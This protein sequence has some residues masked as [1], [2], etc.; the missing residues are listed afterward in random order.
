VLAELAQALSKDGRTFVI[1]V[2]V[3]AED[4]RPGGDLEQEAAALSLERAR[5]AVEHLESKGV[6]KGRLTPRGGGL[7]KPGQLLFDVA[8]P[9][10]GPR[11]SLDQSGA[12]IA[13]AGAHP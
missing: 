7:A 11:A 12:S 5:A 13:I 2:R 6:P 3:E 9:E 10:P 4:V 1:E 8:L